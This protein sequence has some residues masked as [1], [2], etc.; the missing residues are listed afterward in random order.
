MFA[1][2]VVACLVGGVLCGRALANLAIEEVGQKYTLKLPD[3]ADMSGVTWRGDDAFYVVR[4]GGSVVSNGC[5]LHLMTPIFDEKGGLTRK[6]RMG[7]GVLL[8]GAHDVEGV[9]RDPFNGKIWVSDEYDTSIR[10]YDPVTGERTGRQVEVPAFIVEHTRDNLSLESFAISPDGFTLWTANEEALDC[11]GPRASSKRG[12]VVR[13]MRFT[14]E[15]PQADW[16]AAGMWAYVCEKAGSVGATNSGV[17]DLC[18]LPD[19]SLLVLERECSY[20]TL[21]LARLYRPDFT[22][23]TDVSSFPALEGK[24]FT[25]VK[26]GDPLYTVRDGELFGK[27]VLQSA[28]ACYEGVCTGPR[29]ADGTLSILLVSDGGAYASRSKWGLT[30]TVCTQPYVRALALRGMDEKGRVWPVLAQTFTEALSP[31]EGRLGFGGFGRGGISA[32]NAAGKTRGELY[33]AEA[34]YQHLLFARGDY[35]LRLGV[36]GA[37]CPRQLYAAENWRLAYGEFRTLAIPERRL[38]KNLTVGMRLGVAFNWLNARVDAALD[39]TAFLAQGIVGLQATYE[40]T[41]NFGIYS[42]FDWRLGDT[43]TYGPKEDPTE[44]DMSGWLWNA[45]I[46]FTF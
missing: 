3:F 44:V 37:F 35:A 39:D 38:T 7:K 29:N 16:V 22:K 30:V 33:G 24:V 25:P 45:G 34:D 15:D 28:V 10:E 6:P 21:G 18:V 5:Y 14:R 13:L 17:S 26:K 46:F 27:G 32:R 41:D 11:D 43:T 12:T 19:D 9:A 4:D 20:E 1:R 2:L 36:G 31:Q 23:A 40:F 8:K 42:G